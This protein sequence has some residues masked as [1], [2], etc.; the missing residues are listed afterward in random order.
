M[1]QLN[2]T[3]NDLSE[4]IYQQKKEK[5]NFENEINKLNNKFFN[6]END[7]QNLKPE[8]KT[9]KQ[10]LT[11][12]KKFIQNEIK[13]KEQK[14]NSIL[15][16]LNIMNEQLNKKREEIDQFIYQFQEKIEFNKQKTE[17][18]SLNIKKS[19]FKLKVLE[20]NLVLN[21]K[22][23]DLFNEIN[24][25]LNERNKVITKLNEMINFIKKTNKKIVQE[26]EIWELIG[27]CEIDV[28]LIES[29]SVELIENIKTIYLREKYLEKILE[30]VNQIMDEKNLNI[31]EK[32]LT[33]I[34]DEKNDIYDILEE[35]VETEDSQ[36]EDNPEEISEKHLDVSTF[37]KYDIRVLYMDNE[38]IVGTLNQDDG[39][40][41]VFKRD[42][43]GVSLETKPLLMMRGHKDRVNCF[44]KNKFRDSRFL[45]C[46]KD[47]QILEWDLSA[48]SSNYKDMPSINDLLESDNKDNIED[49]IEDDIE[50][51]IE[52]DNN[53]N[54][55]IEDEKLVRVYKG[56]KEGVNCIIIGDNRFLYSGGEDKII[57][58]WN[59]D[60][61]ANKKIQEH[62]ISYIG[63]TQSIR[64]L[65]YDPIKDRIISGSDDTNIFI[66]DA[67]MIK[68][69][70]KRPISK[71]ESYESGIIKLIY[72]SEYLYVCSS[73][74]TIKVW[75]IR[76][77][78]DLESDEVK[79]ISLG[80]GK[81][82]DMVLLGK[83][84]VTSVDYEILVWDLSF[85]DISESVPILSWEVTN[86]ISSLLLN[87]GVIFTIYEAKSRYVSRGFNLFSEVNKFDNL[88]DLDSEIKDFIFFAREQKYV[89]SAAIYQKK[90]MEF[91]NYSATSEISRLIPITEVLEY[92]CLRF[93]EQVLD[94]YFE[95]FGF[96]TG[97]EF[98]ENFDI[99]VGR[100]KEERK[101]LK[102]E[103]SETH[104]KLQK[105]IE[106]VRKLRKMRLKEKQAKNPQLTKASREKDEIMRKDKDLIGKIREKNV[107]LKS[108]EK[109][110]AYIVEKLTEKMNE[111]WLQRIS[112][113]TYIR[114]INKRE[115]YSNSFI[116]AVFRKELSKTRGE[117]KGGKKVK[118]HRLNSPVEKCINTMDKYMETNPKDSY[119]YTIYNSRFKL[120]I[121][122]GSSNSIDFFNFL[123]CL[124]NDNRKV[125]DPIISVKW[126]KIIWLLR[127]QSFLFITMAVLFNLQIYIL[128][129]KDSKIIMPFILI[130]DALF[131]VYEAKGAIT[132][133][134]EYLSSLYNVL[135][136]II[137][138]MVAVISIWNTAT[139]I[140]ERGAHIVVFL[141][142]LIINFRAFTYLRVI[143]S[144]GNLVEMVLRMYLDILPFMIILG[145][146]GLIYTI[147]LIGVDQINLVKDG[148]NIGG[149]LTLAIDLGFGNWDDIGED[150]NFWN[151]AVFILG[152]ITLSIMLL[153]L[154]IAITDKTLNKFYEEKEKIDRKIKI[155]LI[156][157]MDT[158]L[159]TNKNKVRNSKNFVYYQ[160]VVL[161]EDKTELNIDQ[162]VVDKIYEIS[163]E[164]KI[165]D[166]VIEIPYTKIVKV[167]IQ[168]IN[169]IPQD[170][171]VEIPV[172]K[173]IEIPVEKVV[174]K[175]VEI[176]KEVPK[177]RIVE[178]PVEY[179][180]PKEVEHIVKVP[181][182]VIV[183]NKINVP[184]YL[185]KVNGEYVIVKIDEV[186]G[187]KMKKYMQENQQ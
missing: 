87:Q 45:S 101:N 67:Q 164:Q 42:D 36:E 74:G 127:I 107:E 130:I 50:N 184:V 177:E 123:R 158:F 66:W 169:L 55:D 62:D 20:N 64:S 51:D 125:F 143:E 19:S 181:V 167:P 182:E 22:K 54:N 105:K 33:Q 35:E 98:F 170:R 140:D 92:L 25:N 39:R 1:N 49:N 136:I 9:K 126:A 163:K 103:E 44:I 160:M 155:G 176:I 148:N 104:Q 91:L 146:F 152:N 93:N 174:H 12:E 94:M 113:E 6:I 132:D 30:K 133:Y 147:G 46:G 168:K 80:E 34:V 135:D 85:E 31:L 37:I 59:L 77:V 8:E 18:I 89:A 179:I 69:E 178:K 81:F 150:W 60:K 99:F 139:E 141:V 117:L 95:L 15:R 7:L 102:R 142:A 26:K 4:K 145:I 137:L 175:Y 48:S 11:K 187:A 109:S 2:N 5:K 112:Q 96:P 120:D 72:Q 144:L 138:I 118:A 106:E 58:G 162:A 154:V 165:I 183:E 61:E 124:T 180:I 78:D 65:E 128:D 40:I 23:K 151:W 41:L 3:S 157:E 172:E 84:L 86:P 14:K 185:Q 119:D 17:K 10:D 27:N 63:H 29:K 79:S 38:Y 57:L 149:Q 16:Q 70:V 110:F 24:Q 47:G 97:Y 108:L 116:V 53:N 131:I 28:S 166:K 161:D 121:E 159:N 83:Y 43:K 134:R 21:Q 129:Q 75:D 73:D 13:Q 186:E 32:Q 115:N 100:I 171:K 114:L 52:D 76:K 156:L 111:K 173:Y 122:N 82:S 56:H 71:I 88:A 90:C 68:E 153:N